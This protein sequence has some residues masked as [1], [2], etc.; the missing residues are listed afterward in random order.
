M[1]VALVTGASQGLGLATALHLA[2]MGE[3]VVAGVRDPARAGAL[4]RG[5][6]T[7]ALG[8]DVAT[9]D[10]T[11]EASVAT[12]VARLLE[13]HGR[14]DVVVNNAGVGLWGAVEETGDDHARILFETNV[15]G[16]L[17]MCRAVLPPMRRQGSGVIINVS[18]LAGRV[19][20]PFSGVYSATKFALEA[21][22]EALHYEVKRFGI[23]V[24][25]IEPGTFA[26]GFHHHR[27]VADPDDRSAYAGVRQRWEAA[28]AR[29]PGRDRPSDPAEVATAIYEAA[30]S[31]DHPLRRLVGADAELIAQLRHDLD[32]T[33]FEQTMRGALDFWE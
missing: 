1:G 19:A 25:I 32:D 16:P 21:M 15:F 27:L 6:E 4:R 22:S 5:A 7:E 10:V 13:A 31:D 14:L 30:T 23:R 18:S 3:T 20:P 24:A 8:L 29:L 33:A 2:R 17:R 12:A 26:S 11:D 9:L 28:S